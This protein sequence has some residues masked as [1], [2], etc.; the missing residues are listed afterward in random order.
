LGHVHGG[1]AP[2]FGLAAPFAAWRIGIPVVATF[3]SWFARSVG[4]SVFR[5]PLQKLLD[6]HAATIAVSAPVV[7][8]NA[9]YFDADWEIIPNGVDT[10]FFKPNGR[11]PTDALTD[12][13]RLLFLG[14]IEPRNGLSTLLDAMPHILAR[15]PRALLTVAG[16]GPWRGYC[17][18]RARGGGP[19]RGAARGGAGLEKAAGCAW[20]RIGR[21]ELAVYERV[22]AARA[23]GRSASAAASSAS[24]P[25]YV[26][27]PRKTSVIASTSR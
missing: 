3:H 14:R 15:Y 16:D 22:L 20:R 17:E 27:T 8:A 10:S 13:P 19:G 18:R 1:L 9:R 2:T 26:R 4:C 24:E 6:R 7:E 5:G 21:A 23:K 25:R 11:R 12:R